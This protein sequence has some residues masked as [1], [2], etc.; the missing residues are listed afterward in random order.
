MEIGHGNR[1]GL[2]PPGPKISRSLVTHWLTLLV[3]IPLSFFNLK[4]HQCWP[5]YY[6]SIWY[7][8]LSICLTAVGDIVWES[9]DK[10]VRTRDIK[11]STKQWCDQCILGNQ[12]MLRKETLPALMKILEITTNLWKINEHVLRTTQGPFSMFWSPSHLNFFLQVTWPFSIFTPSDLEAKSL[13]EIPSDFEC[14]L[15]DILGC[16]NIIICILIFF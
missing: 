4:M 10:F 14:W 11:V 3:L 13:G 6:P 8:H 7:H 2:E 1:G 16:S 15:G 9:L 12:C 5:R